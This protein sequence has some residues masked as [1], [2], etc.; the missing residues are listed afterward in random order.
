[1]LVG[2]TLVTKAQTVVFETGRYRTNYR[3]Y[4]TNERGAMLLREA[5]RRGYREGYQAGAADREGRRRNA[6]RRNNVY[7]SGNMGYESYVDQRQYQYYF[8]RGFQRGYQDGFYSRTRYGNGNEILG[9]ILNSIF[10]A[11]RY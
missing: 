8:Q 9:S 6:W 1:M 4:R 7:M 3:N 5:V 10:R 2:G 11:T